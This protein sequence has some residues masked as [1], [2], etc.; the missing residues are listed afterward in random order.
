[1]RGCEEA[2]QEPVTVA[3]ESGAVENCDGLDCL[4]VSG[5]GSEW[6][7]LVYD[8]GTDRGTGARLEGRTRSLST[9]VGYDDLRDVAANGSFARALDR[10]LAVAGVR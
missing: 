6:P 4:A 10:G 5:D 3:A 1:M 8:Y 2:Q 7:G 9:I